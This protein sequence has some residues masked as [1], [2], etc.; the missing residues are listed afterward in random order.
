MRPAAPRRL[1]GSVAPVEIF[2]ACPFAVA[3]LGWEPSPGRRSLSV[4]VKATFVLAPGAPAAVAPLQDPV[5]VDEGIAA[6][7]PDLVPYKPRVDVLFAGHAHAPGGAPTDSLIARA[8][9]GGFRKS[10]SINGDRAWVPS[11]E[12]LRPSVAVPFRRMPLTYERAVRTGENLAGV[13]ISQGAE[14]NRP[15]ANIAA[16]AEQGGETPGL[17]P[18]PFAWRALRYGL[19]EPALLWASRLGLGLGPPPAGFDFHVFN[20]APAEQQIDEITPGADLLL[21]NLHPEHPVLTARLPVIRIKV[22]RRAPQSERSVEV[23]ARCDT[24]W[25]DTDRGLAIALWRSAVL[26][27]GA[28]DDAV[29]RIVVTAEAE[30]ERIGP[31]EVDRMLAR[32]APEVTYVDPGLLRGNAPPDHPS[33]PAIA[34][35]IPGPAV[36]QGPFSSA[37]PVSL[38][39]IPESG[40][41]PTRAPPPPG[42]AEDDLGDDPTPAPRVGDVREHVASP[43]AP[44]TL[45]PPAPAAAATVQALPF[46]APPTGFEGLGSSPPPRNEEAD[47]DGEDTPPRGYP[48]LSAVRAIPP[49]QPSAPSVSVTRSGTMRPEPASYPPPPPP[50]APHAPHA[51][52]VPGANDLYCAVKME[53]WQSGQPLGEVLARHGIE[54]AA[55]S[56]HEAAQLEA[57]GREGAMGG[58]ELAIALIEG[59]GAAAAEARG[60]GPRP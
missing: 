10:L 11:F 45:V 34:D 26:L 42:A 47:D 12:G 53:V 20:A 37:P 31:A 50:H 14:L 1:R 40:A 16:I 19:D 22:F 18:I 58:S 57:L 25:I 4:C 54:E 9:I 3:A 15:L 8:R 2:C 6:A 55:F 36:V 33:Y 52:P 17:G 48:A 32:F 51:P 30:G 60:G 21:E 49:P 29:G 38:S 7:A 44:T 24:L 35:P 41:A 23:P 43:R 5:R 46:R 27:E 13:D 56:A 28:A 39:S 59:L